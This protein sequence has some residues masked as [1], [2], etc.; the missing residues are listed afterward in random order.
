MTF[1]RFVTISYYS[2]GACL[3]SIERKGSDKVEE[4]GRGKGEGS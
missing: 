2:A 1:S 4:G 3:L